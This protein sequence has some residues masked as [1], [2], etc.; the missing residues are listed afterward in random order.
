MFNGPKKQAHWMTRGIVMAFA[1]AGAMVLT[2]SAH[3]DDV[4]DGLNK[5]KAHA[6]CVSQCNSASLSCMA[7]C[8]NGQSGASCRASCVMQ[9]NSCQQ[10]CP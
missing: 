3:A 2:Q 4:D 1:L 9:S 6:D 7:G 5:I 8:P 10:S